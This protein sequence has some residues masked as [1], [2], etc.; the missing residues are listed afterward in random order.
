MYQDAI[1]ANYSH[2]QMTPLNCIMNTTNILIQ[3]M[4]Q[5]SRSLAVSRASETSVIT[6]KDGRQKLEL[7]TLV[8]KS[9][10][11]MWFYNMNQIYRMKAEKDQLRPK[12]STA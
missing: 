5:Q 8:A 1:E 3:K 9:A 2:E 7:M 4:K 6:E 12:N 10:K 11:I